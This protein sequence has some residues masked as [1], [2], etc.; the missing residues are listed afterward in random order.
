NLFEYN[1]HIEAMNIAVQAESVP[2][3][4]DEELV[5]LA[6]G[7]YSTGSNSVLDMTDLPSDLNGLL[8]VLMEAITGGEAHS[9]EAYNNG[10]CGSSYPRSGPI[11]ITTLT[12][13]Q[14]IRT[15]KPNY[16]PPQE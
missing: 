13:V 2:K 8:E 5:Q 7:Y 16:S 14:I 3:I 4:I 6:S 15:Y 10:E 1:K 9:A 11:K 12:P